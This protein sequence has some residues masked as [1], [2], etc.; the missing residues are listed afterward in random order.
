MET[1]NI[2]S[3]NVENIGEM[4]PSVITAGR[5]EDGRLKKAINFELLSSGIMKS[6][7]ISRWL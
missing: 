7:L 5:G 6:G 3:D 4:F 2:T 1:K